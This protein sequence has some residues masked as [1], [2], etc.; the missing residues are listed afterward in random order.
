M[1]AVLGSTN[2]DVRI[3]VER[4]PAAGETVHALGRSYVGGGKG[5]N[6]ALAAK[7]AGADVAFFSAVGPDPLATAALR[8][9]LDAGISS[10]DVLVVPEDTGLAHIY[11]DRD[12]ENCIVVIAGANASVD[13]GM[14]SRAVARA[15]GGLLIMQQ[16][17]PFATIKAALELAPQ[18]DVRTI[19]N[20]S[21]LDDKSA[22]LA[23]VADIVIANQHEWSKL[24]DGVETPEAML[25]WSHRLGRTIVVTRGAAGAAVSSPAGYFEVRAP[26]V[27]PVDTVGAGDT[28]CGYLAA[29]I[30]AG[31]SLH[32]AARWA[33]MAASLACLKPG[34]QTSIPWRHEVSAVS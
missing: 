26:A 30:D 11:V 6:Q 15:K 32:D 12:G 13:V 20:V 2:I 22:E 29:A 33:V 24:I 9:L 3:E 8:E 21:P 25:N 23:P 16:E 4:L 18:H 1:I 17:I 28:F 7:R 31:G 34:A 19:L 27:I 5:A 10:S 14:A